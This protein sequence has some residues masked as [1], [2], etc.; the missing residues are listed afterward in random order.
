MEVILV[1]HAIA[2][3]RDRKRWPDDALRPLTAAGKQKFRKAARGLA[4]CVPKSAALLTSPYVRARDTAAI[5]A[6]AARHSKA[7][8]CIELAAGE[9][10]LKTFELLRTRKEKTV[11]LV[12]HEPNLSE[13]L[14]AALAGQS[15][16]LKIEFKKGGAASIEFARNIQ[17]G[18][19]TLR[20]MLPPRLLASA[21][22]GYGSSMTRKNFSVILKATCP[23][24]SIAKRPVCPA[25]SGGNGMGVSSTNGGALVRSK[26][27][28]MPDTKS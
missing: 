9:A 20:W 13:F 26:P 3:E 10:A 23:A 1:R 16:R 14:S 7:R 27:R 4:R 11:V 25:T 12:G 15:V 19:A 24:G 21:P 6:K 5:L 28:S 17:P 8:E 22:P 18:D 2:H